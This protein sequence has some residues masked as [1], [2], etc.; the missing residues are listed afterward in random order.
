M[1]LSNLLWVTTQS[2]DINFMIVCPLVCLMLEK[3]AVCS[4]SKSETMSD[5]RRNVSQ[6]YSRSLESAFEPLVQAVKCIENAYTDQV[7]QFE[8]RDKAWQTKC[9]EESQRLQDMSREMEQK[10]MQK[11]AELETAK[12]LLESERK[13]L[14]NEKLKLKESQ[15][16][17]DEISEKQN[18]ITLEVGGDKF[19]TQIA[20]LVKQIESIFPKLVKTLQERTPDKTN[21]IIFIDRDSKHFKFI[22]NYIRQGPSVMKGTVVNSKNA[23][24]Y[25]LNEI[26]EEI[27]YYRLP[28]LEKLVQWKQTGLKPT[29][30]LQTLVRQK[31]LSAQILQQL[32]RRVK[33]FKY[34]S[35]KKEWKEQNLSHLLFES[36]IFNDV[37]FKCCVLAKAT[38]RECT[39]IGAT[40]FKSTDFTGT[41]FENCQYSESFCR[42]E[43]ENAIV[44]P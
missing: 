25:F 14:E 32:Q 18:P 2:H 36:V 37:L 27:R 3:L 38:F 42:A 9:A 13:D 43:L 35:T 41:R 31:F 4:A 10:Q 24:E 11:M 22:L 44:V 40:T 16:I 39:F 30:D 6:A 17:A 8:E 5:S 28:E 19:R 33:P 26:L 7:Q 29:I 23:D 12:Q 1:T 21:R 15:N 20:T 34:M